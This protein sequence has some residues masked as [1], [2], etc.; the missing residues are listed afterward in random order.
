MKPI[1]VTSQAKGWT[2]IPLCHLLALRI[3]A[4][5]YSNFSKFWFLPF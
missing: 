3:W 1:I 4:S 5:Y 2:E